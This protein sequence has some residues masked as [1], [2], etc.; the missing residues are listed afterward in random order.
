MDEIS[1]GI[2][3]RIKSIY[4]DCWFI[5]K[6]YLESHNLEQYN[7]RVCELKEKYPDEEFL[8]DILYGFIKKLN[9]LQARYLMYKDGR[10]G[11]KVIRKE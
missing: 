5:Y 7:R 1:R 6:E 9:I 3:E 8:K 2:E 10:L 4:N 11:Y